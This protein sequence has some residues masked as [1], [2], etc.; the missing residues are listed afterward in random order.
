MRPLSILQCSR[1]DEDGCMK[2]L[3]AKYKFYLSFENSLCEGEFCDDAVDF[4]KKIEAI[5][6]S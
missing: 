5:R 3:E 6:A 1:S 2:M 4:S